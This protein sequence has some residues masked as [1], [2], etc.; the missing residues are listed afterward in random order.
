MRKSYLFSALAV[1]AV[2]IAAISCTEQ[3]QEPQGLVIE[4]QGVFSSGGQV[5]EAIPGEYDP[6][7]NWLDQERKGTTT[8]VDHANT[9]YQIPAGG[10]GNPIVFL[11]GYGQTR[12]GWQST[13]DG[14]EGWSEI[15]LKKGY[16]VFL[17]D[18]PR[19]GAAGATGLSD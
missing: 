8:H 6:T 4:K 7:L 16:S 11:H 5:T 17:V 19:R 2:A 12:T 13:P 14:R 15:F 1:A 18:Q 9:M 10:S 3:K